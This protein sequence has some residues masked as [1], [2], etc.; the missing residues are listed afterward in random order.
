MLGRV[1]GGSTREGGRR[2]AV[3]TINEA[4]AHDNHFVQLG[5]LPIDTPQHDWSAEP[6][7]YRE[8]RGEFR[9]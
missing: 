3:Q 8:K 9:V 7:R 2:A 6:R 4:V 1:A 5:D